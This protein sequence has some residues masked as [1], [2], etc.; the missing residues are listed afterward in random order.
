MTGISRIALLTSGGD[1]PGLNACIRAVFKAAA[2]HRLEVIGIQGGY[3]GMID[4]DFFKISSVMVDDIV[5]RG[6]TVLHASRRNRFRTPEGREAACRQL[7]NAGIDAVILIGG[8]GSLAGAAMFT[9][10]YDIPWIGI[11]KTIDNDISGTDA[12]IGFDTAVNTA[13][14]AIDRIR[15]TAGSH[16]RIHFVEVMGRNAGFIAWHAGIATGAETIYIPETVSY[17]PQLQNLLAKAVKM[18]RSLIVII[19]E[20]DEAGGAHMVAE[21][22]KAGFPEYDIAV[23]VLGYIQRGGSPGCTDRILAARL[24]VAAVTALLDGVKNKMVGE[25]NGTIAFIPLGE[26]TRRQLTITPETT[27]LIDILSAL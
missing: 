21:K 25:A 12:S 14:E 7:K 22:M 18:K 8:D 15:D 10:T 17:L 3:D 20:G 23:S 11:P 1:A 13:M 4:G 2:F 19:A 9:A 5:H 16:N 27:E 24:G 6:G 26:I